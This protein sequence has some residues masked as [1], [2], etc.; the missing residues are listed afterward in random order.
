MET[1]EHYRATESLDPNTWFWELGEAIE[2]LKEKYLP[3][4]PD[5]FESSTTIHLWFQ[6][7]GC[8]T[9]TGFA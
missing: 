5:S 1:F 2:L 7:Y 8:N 4:G 3:Q 9:A 6:D